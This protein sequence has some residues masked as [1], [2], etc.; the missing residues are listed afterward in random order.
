[1]KAEMLYNYIRTSL[2]FLFVIN[3][4]TASLSPK[5]E[6]VRDSEHLVCGCNRKPGEA[7]SGCVQSDL[8]VISVSCR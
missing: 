5:T 3:T 7:D 4:G 1:M 8:I 6:E 2:N